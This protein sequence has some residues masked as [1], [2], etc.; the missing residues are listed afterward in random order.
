VTKSNISNRKNKSKKPE[1]P[2]AGFPLFA[3]ATGSWV[4]KIRGTFHYFGP[5]NEPDAALEKFN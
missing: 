2:Y 3:H 5:W 1:K 4:K